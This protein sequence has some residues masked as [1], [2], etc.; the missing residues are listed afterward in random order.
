MIA[1]LGDPALKLLYP[2]CCR[3]TVLTL[4]AHWMNILW[5]YRKSISSSFL[6]LMSQISPYSI[7]KHLFLHWAQMLVHQLHPSN[8][9][10]PDLQGEV[11]VLNGQFIFQLKVPKD[12]DYSFEPQ[13]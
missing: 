9:E 7:K 4:F 11:N 1:I 5:T 3:F 6:L 12:I 8:V 2:C 13:N 10:K